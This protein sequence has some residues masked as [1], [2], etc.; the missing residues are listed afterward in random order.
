MRYL[1]LLM[2][3]VACGREEQARDSEN[4]K[5]KTPAVKAKINEKAI[6]AKAFINAPFATPTPSPTAEPV[7]DK[8]VVVGAPTTSTLPSV[9]LPNG[10]TY[11]A[12]PVNWADAMEKVPAGKRLATRDELFALWDSGALKGLHFSTGVVWTASA[13]DSNEAWGLSTVDGSLAYSN[14]SNLLSTV[15][16]DKE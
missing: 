6:A 3:L 15:Y 8:V 4:I 7:D 11:V 2:L 13:K 12:T 5:R 10:V 9:E 14:M 1:I 16:V